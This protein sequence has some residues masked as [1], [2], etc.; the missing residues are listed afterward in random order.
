MSTTIRQATALAA[1]REALTA[2]GHTVTDTRTEDG[3][4]A[5]SIP[6]T[7]EAAVIRIS[8]YVPSHPSHGW[9]A[10]IRAQANA[11]WLWVSCPLPRF[12]LVEDTARIVA[13]VTEHA[14]AYRARCRAWRAE[15]ARPATAGQLLR[16]AL[17]EAGH[18]AELTDLGA[19]MYDVVVLYLPG[20]PGE[21]WISGAHGS[22]G[23]TPEQHAGWVAYYRPEGENSV[24]PAELVYTSGNPDIDADTVNLLTSLRARTAAHARAARASHQA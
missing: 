10:T 2:A 23:H 12:G 14:D 4:A 5:L 19:W 15:L 8:G 18:R 22:T 24:G 21:I 13:V 11:R 16:E 17:R 7:P 9:H 6:L 1:L 3:H 20:G